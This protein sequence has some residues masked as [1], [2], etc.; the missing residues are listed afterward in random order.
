MGTPAVQFGRVG[1]AMV[2][3]QPS[4]DSQPGLSQ[5]EEPRE[6]PGEIFCSASQGSEDSGP[7]SVAQLVVL[8]CQ[9]LSPSL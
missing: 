4:R 5:Q 8:A 9:A 6:I 3:T 7:T 2:V 1:L